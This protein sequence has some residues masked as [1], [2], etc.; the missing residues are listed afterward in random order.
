MAAPGIGRD[1]R[2]K[3]SVAA[4]SGHVPLFRGGGGRAAVLVLALAWLAAPLV[5]SDFQLN[6]L[7][8]GGTAAIGAIGLNLLTG[9]TGQVSLGHGVFVG[10][11]AYTCAYAGAEHGL[12][13]VLWLP[14]A[15]ALGGA[16]G[17][18]IG[19]F[20]LR[21]RGNYLVI[22]TLGL[23]FL[24]EHVFENWD[25]LTG[26][27]F[28][29][30]TSGAIGTLDPATF[31]LFGRSFTRDQG[32]FWLVWAVVAA[33]ALVAT[34]I[35]RSRP[36][37]AM[38]AVRD[39]D[40]AA[41]VIGVS[42]ARYKVGAF[43]VSSAFAAAGGALF[44]ALQVFVDPSLFG[45]VLSIQFV[46]IIVIGGLGT[47][48]GSV[49]GAVVLGGLPRVIEEVTRGHDLPFVS[50][51]RGGTEGFLAVASLNKALYGVL[52]ILFLTAQ[53]LGLAGFGRRLRSVAAG[54]SHSA[55][56]PDS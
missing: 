39:R 50:G 53:P 20:A 10:I 6:V 43:A 21:L 7:A 22:V 51:D 44:G 27:S 1:S 13:L 3:P 30:S 9:Y 31:S 28:G 48:Y 32:Y 2:T 14:L 15:A 55:K 37:R 36:G 40:L 26:G 56:T 4:Y 11:G 17:A 12:P 54:W 16:V 34:N 45:L 38:Q 18:V 52:I 42:Q 24:G 19:P 8:Y 41:E 25:S 47:V 33:A 35:V 49:L 23:V 29:R 46:A 5:L